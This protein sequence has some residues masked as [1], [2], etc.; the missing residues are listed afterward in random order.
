VSIAGPLTQHTDPTPFYY[1]QTQIFE[2]PKS[3]RKEEA[4]S[5]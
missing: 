4:N 2:K 3:I 1:H 5:R